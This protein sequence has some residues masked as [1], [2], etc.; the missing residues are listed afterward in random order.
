MKTLNKINQ[1]VG[2]LR[3]CA[4]M[5][6]VAILSA[7]SLS[8]CSDTQKQTNE[9]AQQSTTTQTNTTNDGVANANTSTE[10]QTASN[11]LTIYDATIIIAPKTALP[12]KFCG[13]F[14][15]QELVRTLYT[16]HLKPDAHSTLTIK[17][18]LV[19]PIDNAA[20]SGKAREYI[21]VVKTIGGDNNDG[22]CSLDIFTF[23]EGNAQPVI[24]HISYN[25]DFDDVDLKSVEYNKYRIAENEFAL[26][27]E[28]KVNQS[29]AQH[30]QQSTMLSLFRVQNDTMSPLFE[31]AT[32]NIIKNNP[33]GGEEFENITEDTA[34][35]ETMNTWGKELYS[36]LVTRTVAR[37]S[38]LEGDKQSETKR[39][40]TL[41]QW[42]G[43]RYVET[44][45]LL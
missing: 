22:N 44:N 18:M 36:L 38:N 21:A 45:Q 20:S 42:D 33:V 9:T 11:T 6:G 39:T 28:W 13:K 15:V 43:E 25:P 14:T 10:T 3:L 32:S 31:L 23:R 27:V 24:T 1:T 37:K 7:M 17:D 34:A 26:A 35:L 12:E 5:L 2:V 8:S 16:Q 30:K 41:Y 19:E 29:D 40:K 4:M